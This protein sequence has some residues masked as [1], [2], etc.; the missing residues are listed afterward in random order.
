VILDIFMPQMDG[1]KSAKVL[2]ENPRLDGIGIILVSS[3][4]ASQLEEIAARVKADAVVSKEEARMKLVPTV[5]RLG[6]SFQQSL[7]AIETDRQA[8]G[9]EVRKQRGES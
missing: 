9:R 2:R 5:N 1:D 4:P 6:R 8:S 3:C 7:P